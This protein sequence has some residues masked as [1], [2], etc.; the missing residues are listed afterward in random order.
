MVIVS[1]DIFL[2][3][4]SKIIL[5][6]PLFHIFLISDRFNVENVD[7]VKLKNLILNKISISVA[8]ADKWL[9]NEDA[10]GGRNNSWLNDEKLTEAGD[11]ARAITVIKTITK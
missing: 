4:W 8:E 5:L 3:F 1:R 11:A 2:F 6:K 10:K 9:S 7:E